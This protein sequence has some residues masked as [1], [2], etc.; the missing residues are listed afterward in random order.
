MCPRILSHCFNWAK[1]H[2]SCSVEFEEEGDKVRVFLRTWDV[3]TFK[4]VCV[5]TLDR[6]SSD[7]HQEISALGRVVDALGPDVSVAS[8]SGGWTVLVEAFCEYLGSGYRQKLIDH[9]VFDLRLFRRCLERTSSTVFGSLDGLA[10][11]EFI[12]NRSKGA[13]T[14][15]WMSSRLALKKASLTNDLSMPHLVDVVANIIGVWR[16]IVSYLKETGR[17]HDGD[18][19][20]VRSSSFWSCWCSIPYPHSLCCVLFQKKGLNRYFYMDQMVRMKF[21]LLHLLLE[22]CK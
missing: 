7:P 5:A 21:R 15:D 2:G 22:I 4:R 9:P 11:T 13:E 1:S 12:V 18:C 3:D 16:L 6:Y 20:V 8:I 10:M 14:R 19:L 17:K